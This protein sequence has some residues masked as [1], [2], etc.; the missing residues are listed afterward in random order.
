MH[1]ATKHLAS[2]RLYPHE[3]QTANKFRIRVCGLRHCSQQH[4]LQ[5]LPQ[6]VG[7]REGSAPGFTPVVDIAESDPRSLGFSAVFSH[8]LA[9][10]EQTPLHTKYIGGI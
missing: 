3:N 5:Q 10:I 4:I 6:Q 9:M 1:Y 7:S 2:Q 8:G